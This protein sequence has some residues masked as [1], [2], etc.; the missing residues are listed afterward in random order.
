MLFLIR[1][2]RRFVKVLH[3]HIF[4]DCAPVEFLHAGN[5]CQRLVLPIVQIS[6]TMDLILDAT[7]EVEEEAKAAEGQKLIEDSNA[8]S[9]AN[10][11]TEEYVK[12]NYSS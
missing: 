10:N 12:Y 9:I 4:A 11:N 2:G 7:S 1:T 5:F 8:G 3:V 6:D